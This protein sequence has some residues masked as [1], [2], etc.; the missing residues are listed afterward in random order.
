VS[1]LTKIA[2]AAMLVLFL[3]WAGFQYNDPDAAAWIALYLAAAAGCA[4]AFLGR[5]PR[6]A[7]LIYAGLC[8]GWALYLT[9]NILVGREFFFDE[10]GREAMGLTI[11]A[12]WMLVLWRTTAVKSTVKSKA[13]QSPAT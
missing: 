6:G 3:S 11:C 12:G 8:V 10:R 1:T 2:N 13:R 5:F 4:L 9:V 7:A